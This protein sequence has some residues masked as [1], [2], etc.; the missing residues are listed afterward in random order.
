MTKVNRKVRRLSTATVFSNGKRRP[1]VI[2]LDPPGDTI[3]FRLHG[4]RRKYGLPV[5]WMYKTAA[6][7]Q[8][9]IDRAERRARK[10]A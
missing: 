5:D 1:I 3:S 10:K 4:E 9:A 7:K 8:A 2:E 6:V